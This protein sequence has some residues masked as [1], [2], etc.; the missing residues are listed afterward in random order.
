VNADGLGGGDADRAGHDVH[1]GGASALPGTS[2]L[3]DLLGSHPQLGEQAD[4]SGVGTKGRPVPGSG[5]LVISCRRGGSGSRPSALVKT[6]ELLVSGAGPDPVA[7]PGDPDRPTPCHLRPL[8]AAFAADLQEVA[9]GH[10]KTRSATSR[11]CCP[12]RPDVAPSRSSSM[13]C[14]PDVKRIVLGLAWPCARVKDP[15]PG[16][17]GAAITVAC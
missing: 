10:A 2:H 9:G 1:P 5:E 7:V 14:L 16:A 15:P 3:H 4:P 12:A 6:A 11:P 17:P 8:R 13:H